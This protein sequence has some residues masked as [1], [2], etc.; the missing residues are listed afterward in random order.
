MAGETT[1]TITGN[2]T[3]DPEL[4]FTPNGNAVTNFTVAST[5]RFFNKQANQWEDGETLFLNCNVW[6]QAAENAAESLR[7]GFRV[8]VHG[9][10]KVRKYDTKEG[11]SRTVFEVE[12]DSFGPDLTNATAS[13]AKNSR[14]NN[15]GNQYNG[16]NQGG[17]QNISNENSSNTA[18]AEETPF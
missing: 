18:N 1:I 5:P 4:R 16:G 17:G 15:G 2:L 10:L 12:V 3:K 9:R 8:I 14:P 13:V 6:K 7:K 11:E